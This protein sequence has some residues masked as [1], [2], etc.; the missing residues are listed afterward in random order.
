MRWITFGVSIFYHCVNNFFSKCKSKAKTLS[1]YL[2]K[3]GKAWK[4]KIMLSK[5][6]MPFFTEVTIQCVI[7]LLSFP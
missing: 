6:V 2:K 3:Y 1:K 5:S 7:F 4:S